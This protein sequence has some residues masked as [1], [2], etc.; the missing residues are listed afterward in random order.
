MPH[1]RRPA[2]PPA[3]EWEPYDSA[4]AAVARRLLG[5]AWAVVRLLGTGDLAATHLVR[6]TATGREAALRVVHERIARD[7]TACAHIRR[8]VRAGTHVQHP[9]LVRTQAASG[10][11]SPI[12]WAICDLVEGT[13]LATLLEQAGRLPLQRA[14]A[15]ARDVAAALEAAHAHG[16]VHGNLRPG[17]VLVEHGSGRAVV[18]AV[19]SPLFGESGLLGAPTHAAPEQL[20]DP[21]SGARPAAD[22]FALGSILYTMLAGEP[23]FHSPS[24]FEEVKRKQAGTH[25]PVTQHAPKT[26]RTVENLLDYLLSPEPAARGTA[27]QARTELEFIL[28]SLD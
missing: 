5:P 21:G 15:I 22:L 8:L 11:T 13:D 27:A 19:D 3:T 18:Y 26:P 20:E 7:E 2:P 1:R 16:V 14:V 6:E 4:D 12:P 24:G 17:D 23:P 25:T 10:D 28:T 9:N